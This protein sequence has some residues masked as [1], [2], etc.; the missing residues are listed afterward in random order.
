MKLHFRT[1]LAVVI[2]LGVMPSCA[3][4]NGCSPS[5][6]SPIPTPTPRPPGT[7]TPAPTATPKATP[8]PA[9]PQPTPVP[10]APTPAPTPLPPAPTPVPTPAPTPAPACVYAVQES[11]Q[12]YTYQG[13]NGGFSISANYQTCTWA[14][15]SNV[16]WIGITSASQGSGNGSL[17]YIVA[18]NGGSAR[19]GTIS[20]A[21]KTVTIVQGAR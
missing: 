5:G 13:G 21:G 1:A 18:G 8:P 14:A 2:A 17:T 4:C 6:P 15:V 10:P 12:N 7:P 19:T 3:P 9:P 11:P 16:F 20:I